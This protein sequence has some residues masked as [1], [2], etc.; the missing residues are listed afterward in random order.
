M[1]S[2]TADPEGYWRANLGLVARLLCVW[3]GVSYGLGIFF[4]ERLN[5]IQIGGFPLGFWFAHQGSIYVFIVLI[6]TY[7]RLSDRMAKRFGVD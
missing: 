3:A 2:P 6:W 5:A 1:S 4:V 7:A